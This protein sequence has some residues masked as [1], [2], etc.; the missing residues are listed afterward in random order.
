MNFDLAET[1]ASIA[2]KHLYAGAPLS[3]AF[4]R[5]AEAVLPE[6][7]AEIRHLVQTVDV[8]I[9]AQMLR[10]QLLAT[11]SQEPPGEEING[12]CFGLVEAAGDDG[13]SEDDEADTEG[14]NPEVTLYIC[15]SARF[16]PAE[17]DWPCNPEWWPESRY[18]ALPTFKALSDA[19]SAFDGDTAWLISAGLIEPL[20]IVLVGEVC[21]GI[22][23]ATLLG[24]APFRGIGSGFDSGDLRDVGVVTREGFASPALLESADQLEPPAPRASAA[25]T[26]KRRSSSS[27]SPKAKSSKTKTSKAKATKAKTSKAKSSKAKGSPAK[28]S[29]AKKAAVKKATAKKNTTS[30]KVASKKKAAKRV[31]KKATNKATNKATKKATKKAAK[32]VAKKA[33]KKVSKKRLPRR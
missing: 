27:G 32:R 7:P 20:S 17:P 16:D 12:L 28:R 26:P 14:A 11:L 10:E 24:G 30:K 22:E 25:T 21:R 29:S 8:G 19:A 18:F 31:A 33:T 6:L 4:A 2:L 3:D 9:D 13:A 5:I 15:G 23:P 1:A